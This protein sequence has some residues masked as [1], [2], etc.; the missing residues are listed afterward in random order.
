AL[1]NRVE[2]AAGRV[3]DRPRRGQVRSIL[4]IRPLEVRA[5]QKVRDP[6]RAGGRVDV[7]GL[8]LQQGAQQLADR[9]RAALLDLQSDGRPEAPTAEVVRHAPQKVARLVFADL[10]VG[11]ARDSK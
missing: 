6:E 4:Q 11:V 10:D 1:S 7:V 9:L 3:E 2:E 5:G 8:Q